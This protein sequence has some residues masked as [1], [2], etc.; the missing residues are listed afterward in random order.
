MLLVKEGIEK[1]KVFELPGG[2]YGDGRSFALPRTALVTWS[3]TLDGKLYQIYVNS[4]FAGVTVDIEQRRM[5]VSLPSEPETPVRIEV[6]G[7]DASDAYMDLSGELEELLGWSGRVRISILRSQELPLGSYLNVYYNS[8]SGEIDYENA[9]NEEAM[10]IWPSRCYKAGFGLDDFGEGD[11]G[12]DS[13][14][15]VGFGMGSFGLGQFGLDADV[16][17]WTSPEFKAG[18]YQF[19][20]KLFDPE[21][22]QIGLVETGEITVTPAARSAEGL[23]IHSFDKQTNELVLGIS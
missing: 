10:M 21:G 17:E 12:F 11:F 15:A 6:F 4:R 16:I 19:G 23:E 3:S 18:V 2:I 8:G 22:V 9:L 20:L 13:S 5:V 7:V 1:V 14:A